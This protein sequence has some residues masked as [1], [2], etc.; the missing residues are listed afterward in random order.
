[1]YWSYLLGPRCVTLS[2][3]DTSV[4]GRPSPTSLGR[5]GVT[6]QALSHVLFKEV[7]VNA[8]TALIRVLRPFKVD[9]LGAIQE[10]NARFSLQK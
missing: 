2:T 3:D 7:G 9:I 10:K 6:N 8:M 5:L 4:L 1:M